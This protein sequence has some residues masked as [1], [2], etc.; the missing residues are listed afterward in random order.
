MMTMM[1]IVMTMMSCFTVY[2]H[3][4]ANHDNLSEHKH[5]HDTSNI[6]DKYDENMSIM[7]TISSQVSHTINQDLRIISNYAIIII[8]LQKRIFF[9]F[10]VKGSLHLEKKGVKLTE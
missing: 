9:I 2:C 10:S 7:S 4:T 3:I 5:Y 6:R 1:M 8:C